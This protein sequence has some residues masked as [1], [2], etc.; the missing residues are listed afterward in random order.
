MFVKLM[1][2]FRFG[3]D[4]QSSRAAKGSWIA[5]ALALFL[6]SLLEWHSPKYFLQN[7]NLEYFLPAFNY[8]LHSLNQGSL[9]QYEY[10]QFT[11]IPHLASGQTATLYPPSSFSVWLSKAISG[12]LDFAIEIYAGLHLLFGTVLTYRL[13]I[14]LGLRPGLAI[15]GS[16]SWMFCPYVMIVG[17]TWISVVVWAA[18]FPAILYLCLRVFRFPQ[19]SSM[20]LLSC[21]RTLLCFAGHSQFFILS[22][23]F[24]VLV[25]GL[26]LGFSRFKLARSPGILYISSWVLTALLSLPFLLPVAHQVSLSQLRSG[27][28]SMEEMSRLGMSTLRFI[29]GHLL[30][31][32]W[33][34]TYKEISMGQ[35]IFFIS[36][37]SWPALVGVCFGLGQIVRNPGQMRRMLLF[38]LWMALISYCWSAN[39]FLDVFARLPVLSSFRWS[40]KLQFFTSFFMLAMAAIAFSKLRSTGWRRFIYAASFVNFLWFYFLLPERSWGLHPPPSQI[41]NPF[42]QIDT[43]FRMMT[44]GFSFGDMP[45]L[46]GLGLGYPLL[47]GIPHLAGYEPLASK[48]RFNIAR[49]ELHIGSFSALPTERDW[50]HFEHWSVTHF[51]VKEARKDIQSALLTRG[52]IEVSRIPGAVLFTYPSPR[53]LGL[54]QNQENSSRPVQFLIEGN[55]LS[56]NSTEGLL[57]LAFVHDPFHRATI[58]GSEVEFSSKPGSPMALTIPAGSHQVRILYSNPLLRRGLLWAVLGSAILIGILRLLNLE[59]AKASEIR[60]VP[61]PELQ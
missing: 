8:N 60:F 14:E 59:Y 32:Y 2:G 45:S 57:R 16:L 41:A 50:E 51:V 40:F 53:P 18:W 56:L 26:A 46:P 37:I 31:F 19:L 30:P 29:W 42:P 4:D 44:L 22:C 10:F 54:L 43:R 25:A 48:D 49:E 7:D 13:L 24:E 9:A 61:K 36:H 11:G 39:L 33:T 17:R 55:Q 28:M 12:H 5:A 34:G 52:Y 27:P 35:T 6:L 38:C 15:W 58:D 3:L 47:F 20:A 21:A 23:I 1:H